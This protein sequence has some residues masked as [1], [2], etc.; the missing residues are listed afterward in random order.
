MADELFNE[1]LDNMD[2]FAKQLVTDETDKKAIAAQSTIFRCTNMI[3]EQDKN[4]H[5]LC[6]S[7]VKEIARANK[8]EKEL[9]YAKA[10]LSPRKI[11]MLDRLMKSG[12]KK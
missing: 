7:L 10:L 4:I 9:A 8:A 2:V 6:R 3:R 12:D 1:Y 11:Q 5:K